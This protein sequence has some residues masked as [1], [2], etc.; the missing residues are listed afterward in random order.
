MVQT[1]ESNATESKLR[2]SAIPKNLKVAIDGPA[3]A[4]KS[5]VAHLVSRKL[6]YL[7][8]DTGAMYR[9]V[10]WLVIEK[11]LP[12]DDGK[13]IARAVKSANL[14]LIPGDEASEGKV[15]VS[16]AGQDVTGE[17]RSQAVTEEVSPLSSLPE[18]RRLLVE[19]QQKL[20]KN[21]GIVLEGR[22]IGTVVI[23][24][25]DV[26]VF[27]TASPEIRATRRQADLK[28]LGI[29]VEYDSLLKE[30]NE[31]DN[32][33]INRPDSPLKQ[34]SDAVVIISDNMT[35]EQVVDAIVRLCEKL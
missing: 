7:Y 8:I 2:T 25:A 5:T 11:A 1:E 9:A 16:I 6:K 22:D 18:V 31:R 34:A 23:P 21:G 13:A 3:G 24:D 15:K 14:E 19:E 33:D 29:N 27:L 17:I 32:R 28:E 20:S 4:G 26:K 12:R 30:I 35:I 10:A